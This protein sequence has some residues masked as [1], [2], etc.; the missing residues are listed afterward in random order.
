MKSWNLPPV[1]LPIDP[2][3]AFGRYTRG[4]GMK[5]LTCRVA[6]SQ[7]LSEL[8]L[9]LWNKAFHFFTTATRSQL[10][11]R[12]ATTSV[13]WHGTFRSRTKPSSALRL[14]LQ[15]LH[16]FLVAIPSCPIR[17]CSPVTIGLFSTCLKQ[18]PHNFKLATL[19]CQKQRRSPSQRVVSLLAP[20]SSNKAMHSALPDLAPRRRTVSLFSSTTFGWRGFRSSSSTCS[21]RFSSHAFSSCLTSPSSACTRSRSRSCT[22]EATK[23][24]RPNSS[25]SSPSHHCLHLETSICLA[26]K[27]FQR[28]WPFAPQ[29]LPWSIHQWFSCQS[30]NAEHPRLVLWLALKPVSETWINGCGQTLTFTDTHLRKKKR[31]TWL[32]MALGQK[33][34]P[35]P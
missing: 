26:T 1:T 14:N 16:H 5:Q 29:N 18:Q 11:K 19:A 4:G 8:P 9:L 20:A 30:T 27:S 10:K 25:K 23:I 17:S 2:S 21:K 24:I 35:Y 31:L 28:F 7:S 34:K 32:Y 33:V 12:R 22:S 6:P 13:M 15:K 3:K